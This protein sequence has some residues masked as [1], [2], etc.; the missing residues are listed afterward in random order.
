MV[1]FP[2][3]STA[4]RGHGRADMHRL[5]QC[6]RALFLGGGDFREA[7][8]DLRLGVQNVVQAAHGG[9]AALENVGDPAKGDHW[10]DE[11]IEVGKESQERTERNLVA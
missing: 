2:S 7:V 8:V 1:T 3:K 9:G 5:R 11:E 4:T 10:P 6:Y